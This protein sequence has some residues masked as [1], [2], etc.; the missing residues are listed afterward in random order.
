M[1]IINLIILFSSKVETKENREIPQLIYSY[2]SQNLDA[3]LSLN[4]LN[5]PEN[6]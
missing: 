1:Y 6:I 4:S 2:K 3:M 5:S